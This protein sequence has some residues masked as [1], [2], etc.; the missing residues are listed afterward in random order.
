MINSY[1]VTCNLIEILNCRIKVMEIVR[2]GKCVGFSGTGDTVT[3]HF[4]TRGGAMMAF[5]ELETF[6]DNVSVATSPLTI[7][8]TKLKGV[9]KYDQSK[10]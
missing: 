6:L 3:F 8:K 7:D 10:S 2:S 4:P 1:I 9:F 5:L